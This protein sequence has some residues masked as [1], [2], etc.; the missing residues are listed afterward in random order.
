MSLAKLTKNQW[1]LAICLALSIGTFLL[2]LPVR[3]DD[4][5][6]F[7]DPAYITENSHV[8]SGFRWSNVVWGFEHIHAGYWI[9]LTWMAHMIDCQLFGLNTG[10]HHLMS[11]AIHIANAI[12]L[13]LWL[14]QATGTLWR[15]AFAAALFAWHPLRVESVAWACELKDVLC[16]FFWMLTLIA[17][18]SY[19]KARTAHHRRAAAAY[20][21]LGMLAFACGLMSKPMVVTLPCVLLL[22]DLWPLQRLTLQPNKAQIQ[23]FG[24]LFLEKVPFFLLTAIGSGV[25]YVTQVISGSLSGDVMSYRVTNALASYLRYISK[26]FW[27][28]DLSI[29]YPYLTHGVLTLAIASAVVLGI[30]SVAFLL[31]SRRW[32]YL[33]VGWLWF[34]GALTPVIGIIQAGSQSMADRFTYLPGIGLCILVTWGVTDWLEPRLGKKFLAAAAAVS[35]A[36]CLIVT[37]IQITYWRNSIT[38]F[39]HALKV[40]EDNYVADACLGQALE[41]IGD[42]A[43][44][45]KICQEGVRLDPDYSPG[46]FFLGVALWKEGDPQAA[47]EHLDMA[48]KAEAANSIIQY[49][50]GKFL[51]ENGS[52]D[53]AVARFNAALDDEPDFPEA[54]N[55]LGKTLWKLGKLQ[56]ATDHLA[57]AVELVPNNAQFHYDLGTI[58]LADSQPEQAIDQFSQAIQLQPD[59]PLAEQNLAIALAGQG[60]MTDA[61]THFSKVVELQPNNPDARF[62]LGLAYLNTRQPSDAVEQFSKQI[63]LAPND[64]RGFYRLAQAMKEQNKLS[65][66][67][68]RYRQALQLSPN[69]PEA[70]K[71]LDALLAAHPELRIGTSN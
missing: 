40:T 1:C 63:E 20:Y 39:T 68:R 3:H 55:A 57:K 33:L 36:A 44:A 13:F 61:I 50:L 14:R 47:Y 56:P 43:D 69:F 66:A 26:L 25:G 71:E 45:L 6:N 30:C 28:T 60:K 29:F 16:G 8:T 62:N 52:W 42:N 2:Y 53:K 67:A 65:G 21:V 48:A 11:V 24:R 51:F 18:T 37:S 9:P 15:S 4:F 31:L 17:Y 10:D 19:F 46:Q 49:N 5:N 12:L 64:A 41:T 54:H 7:D 35:L 34:L 23:N 70:K 27:P 32:P 59:F 58:L 38:V 22:V